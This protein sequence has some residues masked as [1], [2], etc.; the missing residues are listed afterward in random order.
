MVLAACG[1]VQA[2]HAGNQ[3]AGS[4]AAGVRSGCLTTVHGVAA[5]HG[6]LRPGIIS[7]PS[8]PGRIVTRKA[9]LTAAEQ[10]TGLRTARASVKLSSWT[11]IE[12]LATARG[13]QVPAAPRVLSDS[14]WRPDWAVLLTSSAHRSQVV[15]V[16]AASG[17]AEFS[18]AVN[19]RPAWFSELTD[20]D[21]ASAIQR[22][23][24]GSTA[25]VPFG[26]LTRDEQSYLT[27]PPRATAHATASIRFVLSTVPAV[28]KAD[29]G[30]YGGCVTTNCSIRQLVWVTIEIVRARPGKTVACLPGAISVPA[31]YKAKQVKQYFTVGVPDNYGVGCGPLPASLERLKNLAPPGT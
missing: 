31:G 22:C 13:H 28:N 16:D 8:T 12:A 11:E 4:Q 15:V 6:S 3:A 1:Q 29:T 27:D 2:R 10:V 30:L 24:G 26:V 23:P 14:P 20:R 17:L 18:I 5:T 19:G 7:L 25:L 21:P 9:A